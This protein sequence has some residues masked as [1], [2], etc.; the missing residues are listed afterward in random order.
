MTNHDLIKNLV[1]KPNKL[2]RVGNKNAVIY[3]RVSTKEQAD[4][5]MS[6]DT[7]KRYCEEFAEKH[8]FNV[9]KYFGGTHESGKTDE[10]KYLQQMLDF[11]NKSSEKITYIIVYSLDRFSRSGGNAIYI[12]EG[13]RNKGVYIKSCTQQID[14]ATS[15]GVFQQNI[16]HVFSQY[17]N[18][19]RKEKC[20]TGMREKLRQGYWI[21]KAPLGYKHTGHR[22]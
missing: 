22:K 19:Q 2:K 3:T 11:V 6:L 17:D 7:Q 5:N 1:I 21:G 14:S 4:N 15:S 16:H 9:L 20:V 8:G 18:E 12:S 13:L 10:R